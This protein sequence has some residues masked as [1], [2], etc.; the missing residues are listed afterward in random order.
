MKMILLLFP[1]LSEFKWY[2]K[3]IGG[4]WYKVYDRTSDFGLAGDTHGWT[5]EMPDQESK[6]VATEK[7]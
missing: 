3:R 7:Y 2:R 5:Q 4:T 1:F 6:I